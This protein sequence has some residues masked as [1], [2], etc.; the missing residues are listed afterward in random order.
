MDLK[1]KFQEQKALQELCNILEEAMTP[2]SKFSSNMGHMVTRNKQ[3]TMQTKVNSTRKTHYHDEDN[4]QQAAPAAQQPP[5]PPK[6][7]DP[8]ILRIA[9]E[10]LQLAKRGDM[11]KQSIMVLLNKA[12]KKVGG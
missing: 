5:Q 3:R 4:E 8:R 10:L 7:Q 12:L 6:P 9:S 2:G 11:A 1:Q